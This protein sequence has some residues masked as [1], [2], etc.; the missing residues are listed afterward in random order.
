MALDTTAEALTETFCDAVFL[1][2]EGCHFVTVWLDREDRVTS[3]NDF[4]L[5]ITG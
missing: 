1:S 5:E 3:M 4:A 2:D